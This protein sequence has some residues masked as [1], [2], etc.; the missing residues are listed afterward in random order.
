MIHKE[1]RNPFAAFIRQSRTGRIKTGQTEQCRQD[2][3]IIKMQAEI[4]AGS[5]NRNQETVRVQ[6]RQKTIERE[7]NS[8]KSKT[9]ESE[10][11]V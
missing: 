11:G 3:G 4:R 9:R 6:A 10:S 5:N 7:S 8:P 2:R 1:Q